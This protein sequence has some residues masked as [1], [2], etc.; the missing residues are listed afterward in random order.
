MRLTVRANG[1]ELP[2]NIALLL[3]TDDPERWFP[4]AR[5]DFRATL[6]VHPGESAAP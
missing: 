4:G 3:F 5:T 2:R 6:P 1:A